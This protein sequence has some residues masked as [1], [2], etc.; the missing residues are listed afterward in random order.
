MRLLWWI[1]AAENLEKV[2]QVRRDFRQCGT[3]PAR[4][5][6]KSNLPEDVESFRCRTQ[7]NRR[8]C[9]ATIEDDQSGP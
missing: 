9:V 3:L 5:L 1:W 4:K 7:T 2:E 8:R 6:S